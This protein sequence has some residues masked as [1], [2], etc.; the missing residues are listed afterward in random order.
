MESEIQIHK[1]LDH[2]NVVKFEH[3]FEDEENVYILLE[4]CENKSLS[5]LMRKRGTLTEF[6]SRFYCKQII[7]ALKY[8]QSKN[9]LHRDL[10]L[11][12]LLLDG[13]MNIKLGDFGLA[14]FLEKEEDLRCS[15]CGTPNYMAPEVVAARQNNSECGYTVAT[16]VWAMGVLLYTLVVGRPPFETYQVEE[17]YKKIKNVSYSFPNDEIRRQLGVDKLSLEFIDLIR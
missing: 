17:T 3:F 13:N 6:E 9:V 10:K 12:N 14:M 4:L 2:T 7:N 15:I 1:Q 16:D 8:L 5:E 11:G